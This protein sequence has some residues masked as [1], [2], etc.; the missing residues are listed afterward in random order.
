MIKYYAIPKATDN[1][2]L[3]ANTYVSI[4]KQAK[5]SLK[6]NPSI[7]SYQIVQYVALV[8]CDVSVSVECFLNDE[9][10]EP[11]H[12]FDPLPEN[13]IAPPE[14][15]VYY[16]KMPIYESNTVNISEDIA[17]YEFFDK[18]WSTPSYGD[19]WGNH[20]AVRKGTPAYRDAI[21]EFVARKKMSSK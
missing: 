3:G 16:G 9:K 1:T 18:K 11:L 8:C 12:S 19:S 17:M 5:N 15:F 14:G 21:E 2:W 4:V 10:D 13:L 6:N 7:G 20:Y